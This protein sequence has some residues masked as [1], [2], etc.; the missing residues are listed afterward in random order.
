M[1]Q[2]WGR[3]LTF[4]DLPD[5]HKKLAEI[6]GVEAMLK[7]SEACG[8]INLY[9]PMIDGVKTAARAKEIREEYNGRNIARLARKY[10]LSVRAVYLI[11]QGTTVVIDG[12]TNMDDLIPK[13]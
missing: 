8:G 13:Q 5:A 2:D 3:R 4:D 1:S 9:I 12:Q 10:G 7:L 6:I 11:V